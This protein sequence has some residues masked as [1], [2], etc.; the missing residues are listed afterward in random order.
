MSQE[1]G[2][3]AQETLTGHNRELPTCEPPRHPELTC[4]NTVDSVI[5]VY[6]GGPA[7]VEIDWWVCEDH[8]DDVRDTGEVREEREYRE[9]KDGYGVGER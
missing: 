7:M 3:T 1:S 5:T 9:S 2:R 6:Y 4:E 8:A